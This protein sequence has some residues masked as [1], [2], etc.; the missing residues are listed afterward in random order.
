MPMYSSIYVHVQCTH[1]GSSTS[2][3]STR[4]VEGRPAWVLS[5]VFCSLSASRLRCSLRTLI[6]TGDRLSSTSTWSGSS[7]VPDGSGS[8]TWG[9]GG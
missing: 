4:G 9:Q 1:L 8:S 2:V 6:L 5:E 7:R 3:K